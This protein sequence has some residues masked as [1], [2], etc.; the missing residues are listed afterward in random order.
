MPARRPKRDRAEREARQFAHAY[1][2]YGEGRWIGEADRQHPVARELLRRYNAASDDLRACPH[3]NAHWG[4]ARFWV[5]AVPE[6]IA[7][8]AC[9]SMVAAEE[10]KRRNTCC[11]MCGAHV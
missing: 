7:C 8:E 11:I 9:T 1:T 5:E 6:L 4:Q 10:Q 2:Q 3:L